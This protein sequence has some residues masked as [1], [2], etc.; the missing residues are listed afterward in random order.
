MK[1]ICLYLV[2]ICFAFAS[3]A[4]AQRIA[5]FNAKLDL[6]MALRHGFGGGLDWQYSPRAAVAIQGS[7]E[8]HNTAGDFGLFNGDLVANFAELKVD[9]LIGLSFNQLQGTQT[10][11]VGEG[12]PLPLMPEYIALSSLSLKLGHRFLFGK[13]RG[14]WQLSL[15][16]AVSVVRHQYYEVKQTF[17][18][19]GNT[20]QVNIYGT[21]PSQWK[22]E[23][24]Y[25]VFHERQSMRLNTQ[26]LPGI[27]YDIGISRR[28]SQRW[29][30]EARV[31]G[32]YNLETAYQSPAPPNPARSVQVRGHL[33]LGYS[34]GKMR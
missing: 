11:F 3:R 12:R 22:E 21:Y 33:F 27:A 32:Q 2:V 19:T 9:S 34:I 1:T 17:E 26:W 18:L 30:L 25:R 13:K 14:K 20:R 7:W 24:I 10:V 23:K 31:S 15:Q 29:T 28:F 4:G 5:P 6:S 16:P 8:E